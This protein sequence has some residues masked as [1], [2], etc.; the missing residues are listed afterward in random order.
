MKKRIQKLSFLLIIVSVL[1]LSLNFVAAH[2]ENLTYKYMIGTGFLSQFG[3]VV[4]TAP[5]GDML[6]IKGE[7]MFSVHPFPKTVTGN[8]TVIHKDRNGK[9]IGTGKWKALK[10]IGFQSYGNGIPQNLSKD[11]EGGRALLIVRITP[12]NPD[13]LPID[14][15]LRIT[16]TIGDKIPEKAMEGVRLAVRDV[17]QN[18]H[19]INFNR[20]VSG[21]TLFIRI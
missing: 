19:P 17:P 14:A 13:I 1:L 5:N 12:D 20:E 6:E 8:G 3:K 9:V 2:E 10:L 11:F 18:F 16:C 4:S 21:G 7:G 15:F